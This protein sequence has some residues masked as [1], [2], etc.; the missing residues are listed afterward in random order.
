MARWPD[1]LGYGGHFLD[2]VAT[3]TLVILFGCTPSWALILPHHRL[4]IL[5]NT[6]DR[7]S[8]GVVYRGP[9]NIHTTSFFLLRQSFRSETR[10]Y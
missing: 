6:R 8:N 4:D 5:Y 7:V 2:K 10:A 1:G 3:T 9:D